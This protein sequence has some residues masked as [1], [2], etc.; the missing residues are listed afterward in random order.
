[1]GFLGQGK[2]SFGKD[3]IAEVALGRDYIIKKYMA[4]VVH[5]I[6]EDA[7][8]REAGGTGFFAPDPRDRIVT[9]AHVVR[10]RRIKRI[11]DRLRTGIRNRALNVSNDS[12]GLRCEY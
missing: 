4:A 2:I 12:L 3:C 10:G 5:I 8:E 9:A 1:M 7:E 11:D 6:V